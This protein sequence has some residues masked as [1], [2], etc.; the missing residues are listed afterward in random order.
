MKVVSATFDPTVLGYVTF[1]N[2]QWSGNQTVN[3]P[4]NYI[5]LNSHN[6]GCYTTCQTIFTGVSP[7]Y[8]VEVNLGM[9]EINPASNSPQGQMVVDPNGWQKIP[10]SILSAN[11]ARSI[12]QT[13]ILFNKVI[14]S[15]S[16][17]G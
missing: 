5:I 16:K 1:I 12:N 10:A 2:T 17:N 3:N 14:K 4:F 9:I 8:N 6:T 7:V 15:W 13:T 11:P